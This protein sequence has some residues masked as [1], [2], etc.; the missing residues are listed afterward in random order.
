LED[1][2]IEGTENSVSARRIRICMMFLRIFGN[3]FQG[4]ERNT[5][6]TEP[7]I[8]VGFFGQQSF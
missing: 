8:Y 1:L 6:L 4:N 7:G 3:S 2:K 5:A